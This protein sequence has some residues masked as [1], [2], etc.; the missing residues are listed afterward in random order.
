MPELDNLRAALDWAFS[1]D[2]DSAIGIH[3]AGASAALWPVLSIQREGSRWLEAAADRIVV[4]TPAS[5]QARLWLWLGLLRAMEAPARSL[6][7]FER[8]ADLY[9]RL[10]DADGLGYSLLRLG[11][12][13]ARVGDVE[14]AKRVMQEA[15]PLLERTGSPKLL[16]DCLAAFGFLKW[17]AGDYRRA[18]KA[19]R[20]RRNTGVRGRKSALNV[21]GNLADV[22]WALGT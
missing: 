16:G 1:T 3:L 6:E 5:D 8:A 17:R 21:L 4:Q 13:L 18:R 2:G 12:R 14:K 19:T 10:G 7:A 22:D 15:F 11:G 9:R 20:M